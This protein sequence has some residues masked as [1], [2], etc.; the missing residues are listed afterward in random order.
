M[1]ERPDAEGRRPDLSMTQLVAS[2]AAKVVATVAASRLG[3]VGTLTGAA[4]SSVVS[5]AG[6][7]IL[8][9]YLD[10]G[11][12]TVLH[13]VTTDLHD[14]AVTVARVAPTA[15][16][17]ATRLDL[18]VIPATA[19][20]AWHRLD[21]AETRLDPVYSDL[22][23]EKTRRNQEPARL[24]VTLTPE[25]NAQRSWLN[26]KILAIAAAAIF[27]VTIGGI[28]AVEAATGTSLSSGS[29]GD[30]RIIPGLG[31]ADDTA[32]KSPSPS[33][34]TSRQTSTAPSESAT[35]QPSPTPSTSAP[36]TPTPTPSV[37]TPTPSPSTSIQ[38]ET[39]A[40]A[41]PTG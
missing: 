37:P 19:D 25:Q 4:V 21:P 31:K 41:Q 23:A 5:T 2:G 17:N 28:I 7:A 10:R 26:W 30:S 12:E 24:D 11:K 35:E 9:H 14:P 36:S 34:S 27:A 6:S 18:P 13:V 38:Q 29:G 1:S 32:T 16:P 22:Y 33:P 8:R 3:V 40:P 20:P 39:P 15:D